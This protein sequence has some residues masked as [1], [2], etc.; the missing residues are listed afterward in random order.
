MSAPLIGK[1]TAASPKITFERLY[2]PPTGGPCYWVSETSGIL[3]A[4]ME[5]YIKL[6]VE[7]TSPPNPAQTQL[8]R[9]YFEYYVFAPCWE[10]EPECAAELTDLRRAIEEAESLDQIDAWLDRA[11][12]LGINPL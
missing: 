8:I 10:R 1:E 9:A 11:W 7:K 4:A 12:R 3:S 5:A 2:L 6:E